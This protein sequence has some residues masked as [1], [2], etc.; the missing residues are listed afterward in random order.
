LELRAK[1]GHGK[2]RLA[3]SEEHCYARLA[4]SLRW[5]ATRSNETRERCR[6]L[7]R[8]WCDKT[9]D[10]VRRD[11]SLRPRS[12]S[13]GCPSRGCSPIHPRDPFPG[14]CRCRSSLARNSHKARRHTAHSRS[15]RTHSLVERRCQSLAALEPLAPG[16]GR[17]AMLL[18][19]IEF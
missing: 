8:R 13:D 9:R 6:E 10:Q 1:R 11:S 7:G 5:D 2:V 18:Y 3:M 16:P 14:R 15:S 19:R 4:R 12:Q 17:Q